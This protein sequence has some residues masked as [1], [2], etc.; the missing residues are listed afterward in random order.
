MALR[1]H[2]LVNPSACKFSGGLAYGVI[3]ANPMRRGGR[4]HMAERERCPNCGAEMPVNAPQGLC[5]ACLLQQGMESDGTEPPSSTPPSA[6]DPAAT[7]TYKPGVNPDDSEIA[8]EARRHAALLRRL[9]ADQGAG[10]GRHG[11]CL[12]GPPDQPEPSR[13]VEVAQVR[14]PGQRRRPAAVPERG[15]GG[16]P[17]GPSAHRAD[18][19]GGRA[20]GPPVLQHEAGRR[21]E[22]GKEAGR[23]RQPTRRPPRSW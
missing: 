18:L 3:D 16:R 14:H 6:P 13:R 20:R 5:P 7:K 11:G 21:P 10:P 4:P 22:P 23:L 19:R 1:G 9:R 15:R 8:V 12:Q 2:P 17:P